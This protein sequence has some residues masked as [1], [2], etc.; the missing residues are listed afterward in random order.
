MIVCQL[1]I[2]MFSNMTKIRIGCQQRTFIKNAYRRDETVNGVNCNS[3][4]STICIQM[5]RTGMNC[6][7][8]LKK[9]EIRQM[10]LDRLA[11]YFRTNPLKNFLINKSRQVNI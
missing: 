5:G 3:P 11:L 10:F 1:E 7:R 8:R 2:G 4:F 6:R 9:G